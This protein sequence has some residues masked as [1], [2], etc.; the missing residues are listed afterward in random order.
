MS[1]F[2]RISRIVSFGIVM[3]ITGIWL[4]SSLQ[5][6]NAGSPKDTATAFQAITLG[7][8]TLQENERVFGEI[9]ARVSPSV[10]AITV[11]E[12][13]DGGTSYDVGTG[14][15]FIVDTQGHIVT[16]LHVVNGADRIEIS[17][18]DGTITRAEFVGG[19]EDSDLA[20]IKINVQPERL[21]PVT[22]ANSDQVQIGQTVLAIGN[23]FANDWTLTS[24]IISAV[25]RSISG[26]NNYRIGGVIQTDAAINPGNSGGP[27]LNLRGEVIGV[28]SQIYSQTRSNSGIGFAAP[29]NLVSRVMNELIAEGSVSYSYIGIVQRDIDLDLIEALGLPNNIQGVAVRQAVA[30]FPAALGGLQTMTSNSIDIITAV[31]GVP[32]TNFDELIGYLAINTVP[33]QTISLTVYRGGDVLT[34]PVT[35]SERPGR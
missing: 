26:L 22:L 18:F 15:G 20:V 19:D 4:G 13:S 29:S 14:S 10:V 33:G 35:L 12:E 16:N 34:M 3:L 24:G 2:S 17:M 27:L 31:D 8:D 25:N 11:A 28:N 9:Y 32:M 21:R 23:P 7:S 1:K 5:I 6:G 30:G